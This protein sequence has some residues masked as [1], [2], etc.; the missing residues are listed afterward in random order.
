MKISRIIALFFLCLPVFIMFSCTSENKKSKELKNS[1]TLEKVSRDLNN[2][3]QEGKLKVLTVYSGTSYFLYRGEPMGFE[4]ELL[5]RFADYLDVELELFI[6]DD[7]D[8][9]IYELEEGNYDLV[10]HGLTI[11]SDRQDVVNFSDYLFLTHQVLVQKKPDDW[12]TMHWSKLESSLVHDAIELIGDTVSVRHNTSYFDRLLNLSEEIG[13]EIHIDTLLGNV[14][15]NRIIQMVVD[16][17]VKYT[18]ADNHLAAIYTSYYPILDIEVPISFSQRIAWALPKDAPHLLDTLNLWLDE[19]KKHT[20]YHVIYN[21][22][23]ENKRS[24]RKRIQ[25]DFFSPNENKIS[26]YDDLIR[27]NAEKLGWDWR[28][29]ASLIYQESHFDP[30]AKSWAGARGLMQVMPATARELGIK[31]REDPRQNLEG[32]TKYLMNISERFSTIPDSVEQ[33]K[34]VMAAYN[35]GY[36]HV[37]DGQRLADKRGLDDKRWDENVNNMILELSYPENYNDPVVRFGYVKGIEPSTYVQQ[38]FERY[39]HYKRFIKL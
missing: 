33:I 31:N 7:I 3:R 22:Y 29:L 5:E 11:T 16:G 34:F 27:E 17:R 10:A 38:I 28:L 23:F 9:L 25:S 18:V 21:K 36:N 39:E 14:S 26:R 24:F 19:M 2:I 13:G 32:G 1:S 35:C 15:T 20:D 37:E 8:S 12:L 30:K 6:S 4:Y